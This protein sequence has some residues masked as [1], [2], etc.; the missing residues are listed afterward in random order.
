V[1]RLGR[2]ALNQS[3]A[4]SLLT[5][6]PGSRLALYA[7]I[8]AISTSVLSIVL[9]FRNS[10]SL[11]APIVPVWKPLRHLTPYV[12]LDRIHVDVSAAYPPILNFPPVVMQI[13]TAD[14][15]R[16]MLEDDRQHDTVYGVIYPDDRHVVVS[17]RV[18]KFILLTRPRC[19]NALFFLPQISTILQ[20]RNLDYGME[21]CTLN[22]TQP[23]RSSVFDP[24]ARFAETSSIDVWHLEVAGELSP[25]RPEIW[26]HAP[27]RTQV[28]TTVDW[29]AGA[30][31]S[32]PEFLCKS[33]GWSSFEL[34][35]SPS[36][37][38]ECLVDFWQD[39]R[40]SPP[41]GEYYHPFLLRLLTAHLSTG[42]FI[43]QAMGRP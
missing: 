14:A 36:N 27:V 13:Q 38:Q 19:A 10:L 1:E 33:G 6:F 16:A 29:T 17:E 12:N 23:L 5:K 42:V 22:I 3:V 26:S 32:S 15:S 35:C 8:C 34:A 43:V 30:T 28:L 40:A 21:T 25:H 18:R 20:F 11:A 41:G 24:A 4:R 9:T 39:Q 7:C 31:L 2:L 37:S